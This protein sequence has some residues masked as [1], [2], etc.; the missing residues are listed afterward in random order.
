MLKGSSLKTL[1]HPLK[2]QHVTWGKPLKVFVLAHA[3][4]LFAWQRFSRVSVFIESIADFA[5]PIDYC[6][7]HDTLLAAINHLPANHC[8][9]MA[10]VRFSASA[11]VLLL[12]SRCLCFKLSLRSWLKQRVRPNALRA[13]QHELGCLLQTTLFVSRLLSLRAGS[14]LVIGKIFRVPYE[15]VLSSFL[16]PLITS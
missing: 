5:N 13:K 4:F 6:G 15:F 10:Q 12:P 9:Y 7:S 16:G 2:K 11:V 1:I 8:V 3:S 14:T